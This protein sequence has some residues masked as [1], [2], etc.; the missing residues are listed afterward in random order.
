MAEN[1]QIT[2]QREYDFDDD[3]ANREYNEPFVKK[4]NVENK[5][6]YM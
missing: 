3:F 4:T 5:N 1:K 6:P 2:L